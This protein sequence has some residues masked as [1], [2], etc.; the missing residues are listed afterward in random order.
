MGTTA[1]ENIVTDTTN[2]VMIFGVTF[3]ET[4]AVDAITMEVFV[5]DPILIQAA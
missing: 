2:L 1:K 4:N 3:T 5:W